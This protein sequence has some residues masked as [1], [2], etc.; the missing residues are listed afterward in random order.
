MLMTQAL[1]RRPPAASRYKPLLLDIVG[2]RGGVEQFVACNHGCSHRS[3]AGE[4]WRRR[5]RPA[6]ID[7][8]N[9]IFTPYDLAVGTFDRL[10]STNSLWFLLLGF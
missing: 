4:V 5:L 3:S 2:F 6:K 8:H 9:V 1:A 7:D 10:H